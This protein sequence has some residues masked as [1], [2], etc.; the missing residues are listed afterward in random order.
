MV[1]GRTANENLLKL[2]NRTNI[3][4]L[5]RLCQIRK[6]CQIKAANF[7]SLKTRQIVARQTGSE[8]ST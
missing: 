3:D 6:F 1:A 7:P 5:F 2:E 4:F 8:N